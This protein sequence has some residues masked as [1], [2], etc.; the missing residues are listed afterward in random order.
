M[1]RRSLSVII[2]FSIAYP[3]TWSE[4]FSLDSSF[5][6]WRLMI[7]AVTGVDTIMNRRHCGCTGT[8]TSH[9]LAD[10]FLLSLVTNNTRT[11]AGTHARTH[12]CTKVLQLYSGYHDCA[13]CM[14]RMHSYALVVGQYFITVFFLPYIL[15]VHVHKF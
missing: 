13:Q 14:V 9:L 1:A 10:H 15:C 11:H 7:A 3:N 4:V 6:V 8:R 12:T 2:R 5:V